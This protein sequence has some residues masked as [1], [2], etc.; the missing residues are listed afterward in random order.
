MPLPVELID[1]VLSHLPSN[2]EE[3]LRSCSVVAEPWLGPSQSRFFV[4]VFISPETYQPLLDSI[5]PKN[6]GLLRH[7]RSLV[8]VPQE[9]THL[10]AST[11]T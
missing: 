9:R 2:D 6:T 3:S 1:E 7:L 11:T 4:F 10:V 5:S 8:Y